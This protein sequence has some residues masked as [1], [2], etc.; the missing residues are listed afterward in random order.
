MPNTTEHRR[1]N[2]PTRLAVGLGAAALTAGFA[3]TPAVAQDL[4]T[5]GSESGIEAPNGWTPED[6]VGAWTHYGSALVDAAE[7]GINTP[8]ETA[9]L[10]VAPS[11]IYPLSIAAPYY[12][13]CGPFV[14]MDSPD[15]GCEEE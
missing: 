11:T 6:S 14:G 9:G 13:W 7:S 1:R 15:E 10:A 3:A 8:A 4:P 2:L 12:P 5:G